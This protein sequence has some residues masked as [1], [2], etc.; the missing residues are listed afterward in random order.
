M[1][2]AWKEKVKKDLRGTSIPVERQLWHGTDAKSVH[3]IC[4]KQFN[5]SY[6][7]KNGKIK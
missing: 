3:D 7:G 1:Y 6:A 5:R 2:H 4:Q